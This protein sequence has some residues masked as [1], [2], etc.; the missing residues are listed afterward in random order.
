MKGFTI[1]EPF[2]IFKP[3]TFFLCKKLTIHLQSKIHNSFT[4]T[5]K[6]Y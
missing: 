4:Y 1:V 2:F 3:S 6:A 5:S